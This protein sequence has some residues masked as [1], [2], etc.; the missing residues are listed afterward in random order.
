MGACCTANDKKE[1]RTSNKKS[2]PDLKVEEI[3]D[4]ESVIDGKN[5]NMKEQ[6]FQVYLRSGNAKK[7]QELIDRGELV[8]NDYTLIGDK[9]LLHE[10]VQL[11]DNSD[12]INTIL[13]SRW[14]VNAVEKETGNTALMLAAVD[15]KVDFVKTILKYHPNLK[16]KNRAGQDIFVF[17]N[18]Y[19]IEKKGIKK[20]DLIPEQKEKF[21]TI[22]E[23]LKE[24]K[25][26][27]DS[28]ENLDDGERRN[29]NPSHDD[30][31]PIHRI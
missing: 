10:A 6:P 23:L 21:R 8:P 16:I 13:N 12:V 11:S 9:T 15:L 7:I 2:T 18:E 4:E 30:S 19:L 31:G 29:I 17:L 1:R 27:L 28:V 24:C 22:I 5:R 26:K 25:M 14:D 3:P 20:T